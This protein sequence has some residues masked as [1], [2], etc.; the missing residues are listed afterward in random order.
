[1][2]KESIA[3]D[4]VE[5]ALSHLAVIAD[6]SS[7]HLPVAPTLASSL[8]VSALQGCTRPAHCSKCTLS[9][10][11]KLTTASVLHTSRCAK[12]MLPHQHLH[13]ASPAAAAA[14]CAACTWRYILQ[15]FREKPALVASVLLHLGGSAALMLHGLPLGRQQLG[16]RQRLAALLSVYHTI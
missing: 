3:A 13:M 12:L 5:L 9:C 11:C 14:L 2:D 10:A 4:K 7:N 16:T 6:P 8:G 1:M 15:R